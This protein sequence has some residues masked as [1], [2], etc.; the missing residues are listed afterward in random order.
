MNETTAKIQKDTV[1]DPFVNG[2]AFQIELS[3][4]TRPLPWH[5]ALY[6]FAFSEERLI[7]SVS[8]HEFWM[9]EEEKG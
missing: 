6:I 3:T 8:S 9:N 7:F 2:K 5:Q 1:K 4:I